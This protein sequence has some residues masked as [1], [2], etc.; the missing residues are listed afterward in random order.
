MRVAEARGL[1]VRAVSVD[2]RQA[3]VAG[4]GRRERLVL[5]GESALAAHRR[6]LDVRQETLSQS[7]W[8]DCGRVFGNFRDGG[9]LTTRSMGRI[10]RDAAVRAG[11]G[12]A[13]HPHLL[14]HSFATHLLDAGADCRYVQELLGHRSLITTQL[15]THVSVERL[16]SIFYS[17]HP[18]A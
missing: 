2:E 11:L 3:I 13:I 16:R 4:K 17:A 6:W 18:R 9:P 8:G 1:L 15:Y 5:L 14:R 12:D 10:V 7:G